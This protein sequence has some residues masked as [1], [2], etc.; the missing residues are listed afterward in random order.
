MHA[1]SA[2][3]LSRAVVV[4]G[5]GQDLPNGHEELLQ[6]AQARDSGQEP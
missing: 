5:R 3:Q 4:D 1:P 2:A 6:R